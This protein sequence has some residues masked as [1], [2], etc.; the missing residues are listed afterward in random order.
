MYTQQIERDQAQTIKAT[1]ICMDGWDLCVNGK[2]I[3]PDPAF[4]K[5]LRSLVPK[6][7]PHMPPTGF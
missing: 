4:Y 7:H 6:V 2:V 1:E 3:R 5:Y